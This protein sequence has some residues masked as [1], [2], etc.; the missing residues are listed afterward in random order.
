MQ[1]CVVCFGFSMD[2]ISKETVPMN[3]SPIHNMPSPR[4]WCRWILEVVLFCT[5][6]ECKGYVA[7]LPIS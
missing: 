5:D 1:I 6:M 3:S 2:P 4:L 7:N